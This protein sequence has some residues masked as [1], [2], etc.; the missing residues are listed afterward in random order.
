MFSWSSKKQGNVA[1][2]TAKA[3]YVAAAGAANQAIW[4]KRILTDMGEIQQGPVEIFCDSKSAIAIAKNP[5][6]HSRTKHIA[7][8]YHF[9]REVEASGEIKLNFCRSED[10]IADIF[11]K[12]LPRDKFQF[13]RMMLGVSK[14]HIKEEY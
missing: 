14:K 5:V 10:Q 7:I 12:A 8:K 1:Q 4:L 9:L 2:S 6:H 13:L 11:T 3:E